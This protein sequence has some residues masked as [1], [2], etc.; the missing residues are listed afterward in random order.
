MYDKTQI[1][2]ETYQSESHGYR[3]THV[4]IREMYVEDTAAHLEGTVDNKS[5]Y[6]SMAYAEQAGRR[7]GA[8]LDGGHTSYF[9]HT[10]SGLHVHLKWQHFEFVDGEQTYCSV[11]YE[12][13]GRSFGQIEK[14]MRFLRTLGRRVEKDTCGEARGRVTDHSLSRPEDV[15]RVLARMK[16]TAQVRFDRA[17]E[18]W[19]LTDVKLAPRKAA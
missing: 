7:F 15:L 17:F 13:L 8:M 2:Y 18:A 10:T 4:V 5:G 1:T 9:D 6:G 19:V 16:K 12:E 14:A 11:A 3:F